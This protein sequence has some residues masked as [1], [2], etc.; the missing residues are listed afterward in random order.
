MFKQLYP[1]DDKHKQADIIYA[2]DMCAHAGGSIIEVH[3]LMS[4]G[5]YYGGGLI[6]R[7]QRFLKFF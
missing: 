1:V 3:I 6:D 2:R 5:S 7:S 4:V